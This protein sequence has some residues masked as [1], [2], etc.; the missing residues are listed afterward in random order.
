MLGFGVEIWVSKLKLR[1]VVRESLVIAHVKVPK[2]PRLGF[3]FK[4]KIQNGLTKSK[5]FFTFSPHSLLM[6]GFGVEIWVSKLKLHKVVRESL[7]IA[8]VKVPK[9][10]LPGFPFI[11][12]IQDGRHEIQLF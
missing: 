10:P 11:A 4:A 7:V 6:L 12:K 3:P 8:H 5:F 1:K 9:N 2:N